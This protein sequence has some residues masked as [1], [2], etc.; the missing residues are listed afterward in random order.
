M[1]AALCL[2]ENPFIV[3]NPT[4]FQQPVLNATVRKIGPVA[5][6]ALLELAAALLVNVGVMAF[7]ATPLSLPLLSVAILTAFIAVILKT[8]WQLYVQKNTGSTVVSD[9]GVHLAR[10]SLMNVCG[11]AG[12]NIAIHEGGH[13]LAA[14]SLF[15]QAQPEIRI[16]PFRGGQTSFVVS[17]GVSKLGKLFGEK[18]SLL[19]VGAAGMMAST[20][21]AMIEF[22]TAF[23][24]QDQFPKISQ[25]L[26]YHGISQLLNEIIYGITALI[27]HIPDLSHD[28]VRL[29]ELGGIHPI[30]PIA[31]M[32]ALPLLELS[33]FKIVQLR[34]QA[35]RISN[36]ATAV[37]V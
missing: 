25:F 28:F 34:K 17:E 29:W 31:L 21:F 30:I 37:F 32:I 2:D 26:T 7:S 27:M 3:S 12:P 20:I 18:G 9:T 5:K 19:F 15:R 13:A 8:S 10:M 36:A 4:I 16:S 33:I 35:N 24:I 1:A 14:L 11:L 23:A 22:A 6:R